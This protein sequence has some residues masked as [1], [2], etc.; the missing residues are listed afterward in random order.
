MTSAAGGRRGAGRPGCQRHVRAGGCSGSGMRGAERRA[1]GARGRPGPTPSR[2]LP[3]GSRGRGDEY[4]PRPPGA[5]P[6][7]PLTWRGAGGR[8][9]ASRT[10]LTDGQPPGWPLAAEPKRHGCP[11]GLAARGAR[12]RGGGCRETG[13]R[14]ATRANSGKRRGNTSGART[15]ERRSESAE[16]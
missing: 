16:L 10:R 3:S 15:L 12:T 4:H 6:E 7:L 9:G 1:G 11:G 14:R 2:A 8:E 5:P 13:S